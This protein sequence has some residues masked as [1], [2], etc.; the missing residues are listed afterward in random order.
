MW[1]QIRRDVTK[2]GVVTNGAICNRTLE[3]VIA[4][5]ASLISKNASLFERATDTKAKDTDTVA[6]EWQAINNNG[7]G[8]DC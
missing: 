7:N 6:V 8:I 3:L 5:V 2:A 1:S 4:T